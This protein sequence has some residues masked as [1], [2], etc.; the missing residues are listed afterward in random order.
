MLKL[1]LC[2]SW[3]HDWRTW[4]GHGSYSL[5]LPALL[6][7]Q[8]SWVCLLGNAPQLC[9]LCCPLDF[10]CSHFLSLAAGFLPQYTEKHFIGHFSGYFQI[11]S[12]IVALWNRSGGAV[13]TFAQDHKQA[14][15]HFAF[16]PKSS[17]FSFTAWLGF[18][19]NSEDLTLGKDEVSE[20][21]QLCPTLYSHG[22]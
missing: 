21:T 9:W 17:F 8:Q 3:L 12:F 1:K 6:M 7:S 18:I 4:H 22:L 5:L 2:I 19:I 14:G 16:L 10:N 13:R 20:V 11:H 15:V